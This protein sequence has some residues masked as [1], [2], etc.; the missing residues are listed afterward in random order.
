MPE[1]ELETVFETER[2]GSVSSS[3]VQNGEKPKPI[4]LSQQLQVQNQQNHRQQQKNQQQQR[5]IQNQIQKQNQIQNQNQIQKVNQIKTETETEQSAQVIVERPPVPP[6][7]MYVG[8]KLLYLFFDFLF[9]IYNIIGW[10][11]IESWGR[12]LNSQE[13]LYHRS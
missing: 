13:R 10:T 1:L 9:F 12:A 2:N 11:V 7:G 3:S 8:S 6:P 4:Q 5:Q